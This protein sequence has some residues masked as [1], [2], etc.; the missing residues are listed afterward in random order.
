MELSSLLLTLIGTYGAPA[1]ALGLMLAALGAPLPS[2]LLVLTGGA[3]V[4]MGALDLPTTLGLAL[5]CVVL[6]DGLSYAMGRLFCG[7]IRRR[8]G[9][10]AAWQRAEALVRRR[11][12]LAVLLTR[13]ALTPLAIPVNLAAGGSGFSFRHFLAYD[14]TGEVIWLLG[15]GAL[16]YL[17]GSQWAAVA[18]AARL[19]L[20]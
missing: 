9:R 11:G 5:G 10:T 16:G 4:Q 13:F 8:W 7:P 19:A 1:L 3:L 15:Y 17:F 20:A 18:G 2:T 14:L 12:G 6:G